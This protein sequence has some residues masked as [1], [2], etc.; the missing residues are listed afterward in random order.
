MKKLLSAL[1]VA[2]AFVAA[3]AQAVLF[4]GA[5]SGP[6]GVNV[7]ETSASQISADFAINR[8]GSVATL[9][10]GVQDGDAAAYNFDSSMDI[11]TAVGP[12][13]AGLRQ[14]NLL[15][16]NGA[17]FGLGQVAASFSNVITSLN[18]TGDRLTLRFTPA[19]TNNVTLGSLSDTFGDFT[20]NRNG[21]GTGDA[22]KL[23]ITAA[24]PE[25]AT[26]A[27][28]IGGLGLVGGTMRHR[29]AKGTLRLA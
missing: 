23:G 11:F 19:E 7:I 25:P 15:L 13:A 29:R 22:F 4:I 2:A 5:T 9:G 24:V 12:T 18:A 26:W 28:M 27:M 8:P 14:I 16:T 21:L 1:A 6:N 17:T 10:F 20:I 3:P